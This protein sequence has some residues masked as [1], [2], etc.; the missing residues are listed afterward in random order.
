MVTAGEVAG[1]PGHPDPRQ[2][3][4]ERKQA[5]QRYNDALTALDETVVSAAAREA[6]ARDDLARVGTALLVFL[7][8]ITA[9]VETKDRE[10]AA[11]VDVRLSEIAHALGSLD[12]VRDQM[13]TVQRAVQM[14]TRTHETTSGRQ[15]DDRFAEG[16]SL[17]PCADYRY[18]GFEDRF[19]GSPEAIAA[20][21]KAYIPIFTA[22]A[23]GAP[24]IDLGC[25]RGELLEALRAAG[26]TARGV[27]A[28]SEMAAVARDRGLDVVCG[29]ALTFLQRLPD[30]SIGGIAATQVV[31]HLEP[32]YLMRMLEAAFRKLQ[33]NAPIVFET[34]NAS[35]WLAFFAS[36]I[37]DLTHVRPIHPETLQFLLRAHGFVNVEIRYSAPVPDHMKMTTIELPASV[38]TAA[39]GQPS[40]LG[41]LAQAMNANATILNSLMFTHYDYAAIGY[42]A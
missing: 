28:N 15:R 41:A 39:D 24:V 18:V 4:R 1:D 5:D 29:D 3:E 9:F 2:R 26:I 33:R 31:E 27:D 20:R 35:C 32:A 37:R 34:I 6:V 13:R 40:P 23:T 16:S 8:Q 11:K 10:L 17:S 19:R 21:L 42:R 12:E 22:Q 30:E 14:L 7:Q 38:T 25:G 36:Y